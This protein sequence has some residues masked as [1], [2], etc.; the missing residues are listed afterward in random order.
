MVLVFLFLSGASAHAQN[1]QTG[2]KNEI[3]KHSEQTDSLLGKKI[4]QG[5]LSVNSFEKLDTTTAIK[6]KPHNKKTTHKKKKKQ[7]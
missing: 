6:P 1:N 7:C 3:V 2:V 4:Q 5:T